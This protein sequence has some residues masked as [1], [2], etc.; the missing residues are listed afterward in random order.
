MKKTKLLF[1]DTSLNKY[2]INALLGALE[3]TCELFDIIDVGFFTKPAD[4]YA[5]IDDLKKYEIVIT[6][7]SFFTPQIWNVH[8]L[9]NQ[10]KPIS[11]E[12]N[13]IFVAGGPHATGDPE[14]TI[15]K[16]G[17]DY[18]IIGEGEVTF[19]AFILRMIESKDLS[20]LKGICYKDID[21]NIVN[22]GQSAPVDIAGFTPVSLRFGRIGPIEITR[23]CPYGCSFCQTGHIMGRCIRH[24]TT[25]QLFDILK[26]MR[27]ERNAKVFRA[28]APNALSYGSNNGVDLNL[29]ELEKLLIT[30]RKALGPESRIYLGTFPS[31]VR[32]NNVTDESM[33]LLKRFVINNNLIIG[34]QSGSERIL[35]SSHRGHTV[36]DVY[37]AVKIAKK[38]GFIANVDF[39]FGLPGETIEDVEM[40][41]RMMSDLADMGARIHAHTFMPLP[42]TRYEQAPYGRVSQQIRD[43]V[44]VLTPKGIVYGNWEE[45]E[46]LSE[47]IHAYLVKGIL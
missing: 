26:A 30:V 11:K 43:M 41:I 13:I 14:R 37:N 45:Q 31:E 16:L 44:K 32:P 27:T 38:H 9:M 40:T 5:D 39:I 1:W 12:L 17:F 4:I 34:A 33:K 22:T 42:Q 18:V 7:F 20:G 35:E 25:D 29:P 28:I 6:A 2:S 23:G 47:K 3:N 8:D 36:D 15:T 10:L 46:R 21:G 24:R 19:P